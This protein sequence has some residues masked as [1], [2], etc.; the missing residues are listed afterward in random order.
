MSDDADKKQKGKVMKKQK[1]YRQGDILIVRVDTVE[2]GQTKKDGILAEGEATGHHHKIDPAALS[3]GL[4]ELVEHEPQ[5]LSLK[6][7][8]PTPI[9]HNEHDTIT[10]PKGNY[11]VVR[12]REFSAGEVR[13][14]LD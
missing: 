11:K 5:D 3:Q 9:I 6:V 12:Q 13:R 14:V 4:A 7:K 1:M 2:E 8:K 10:L